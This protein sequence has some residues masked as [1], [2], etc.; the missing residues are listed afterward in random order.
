VI[1]THCKKLLLTIFITLL[2]FNCN[3]DEKLLLQINLNGSLLTSGGVAPIKSFGADYKGFLKREALQLKPGNIA[4]YAIPASDLPT[5]T[6][7]FWMKIN[8]ALPHSPIQLIHLQNGSDS[9]IELFLQQKAIAISVKRHAKMERWRSLMNF[10]GRAKWMLVDLKWD[11]TKTNP[12][13]IYLDSELLELEQTQNAGTSNSPD[14]SHRLTIGIPDQDDSE[15]FTVNLRDLILWGTMRS[16][17]RIKASFAEGQELMKKTL[18]WPATDL[19]HYAGKQL[20]DADA[21]NGICWT[22]DTIIGKKEGINL[23]AKGDYELSF[24]VKPFTRIEKNLFS[25]E[26]Y[27]K[28]AKSNKTK[29]AQWINSQAD[30][31]KIETFES[32]SI[33]F[34][35]HTEDPIGFEFQSFIP[36]KGSLLLDT[37]S[38]RSLTNNWQKQWRFEDLDHTMGVW[39]EDPEALNGKGWINAHTLDYGPYTCIGQPGKYRATWRIRVAPEIPPET[40]LVLLDVYAHDGYLGQRKGNK[41]YAKFQLNASQFQKRGVWEDKSIEFNYDG[42]D[43]MEFRAFARTLQSP[44]FAIDTVTVT[45]VN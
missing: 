9:S 6:I 19:R 30:F 29:L 42:A 31:A 37:I 34:T 36:S 11:L 20:R 12:F 18:V 24:R 43:M 44:S 26:V 5:G 13:E 45:R 17:K 40:P 3:R 23:P 1:Q 32:T 35:S 4:T 2:L 27:S 7:E 15:G 38:I 22:V 14:S 39:K 8:S 41:S 28:D 21:T 33:H 25:C 16:P 10:P